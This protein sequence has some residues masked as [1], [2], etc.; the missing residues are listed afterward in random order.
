[1]LNVLILSLLKETNKILHENDEGRDT[2]KIILITT[3]IY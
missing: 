3:Y 1:M 2:S